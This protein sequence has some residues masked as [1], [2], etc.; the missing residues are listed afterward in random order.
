MGV[1]RPGRRSRC[2][3]VARRATS[4]ACEPYFNF[5][6]LSRS[7]GRNV[8]AISCVCQVLQIAELL[9]R[10]VVWHIPPQPPVADI[11]FARTARSAQGRAVRR[12]GASL[13]REHRSGMPPRVRRAGRRDDYILLVSLE[14]SL[15]H[16]FHA[17]LLLFFQVFHIQVPCRLDPVLVHFHGQRPDQP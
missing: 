11:H 17:L 6:E 3:G 12:G 10:A 5:I 4:S 2:P 9:D 7:K 13:A 15:R 16:S 1:P 14:R 8:K